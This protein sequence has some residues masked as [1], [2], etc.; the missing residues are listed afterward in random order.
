M[1]VFDPFGGPFAEFVDQVGAEDSPDFYELGLGTKPR[2]EQFDL[3]LLTPEQ[4]AVYSSL[5]QTLQG[6]MGSFGPATTTS[7]QG[8]EELAL[9]MVGPEGSRA[10]SA[11]A[12]RDIISSSGKEF[13]TFYKTNIQD[14]L[15]RD[16]QTEILPGISRKFA[17]SGFFSSDRAR[18]DQLATE[19]LSRQLVQGKART[20]LGAREQQLRAAGIL[21]EIDRTTADVLNSIIAGERA[22]TQQDIANLMNALGIK[23]KENIVVALPGQAGGLVNFLGGFGQGIGGIFGG[24]GGS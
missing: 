22:P 18:A 9:A 15:V 16:F 4:Q 7:L 13:D 5:L 1:A 10:T 2:T 20:Q 6:N 8:L 24:G 11:G 12:L 23:A 19:D 3:S 14:P 21:P 17:G